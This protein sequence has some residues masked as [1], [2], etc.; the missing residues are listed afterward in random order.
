MLFIELLVSNLPFWALGKNTHVVKSDIYSTDT[1]GY[2]EVIFAV[3]Y[4]L[5]FIFAPRIKGLKKQLLHG[6]EKRKVYEQKGYKILPDKYI[7]RQLI[8]ENWD[9]VLRF[10]ATINLKE[11]TASQLFKRLNSYSKQHRL[12]RDLKSFGKI[13][14]SLFIF[15]IY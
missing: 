12:Y 6:L 13:I 10:I 15:K 11:T 5:C 14:K 8:E 7:N 4:L 3:A 1:D 9:D 2:S